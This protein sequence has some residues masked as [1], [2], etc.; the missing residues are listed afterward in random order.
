M[1]TVRRYKQAES[2][3]VL[4]QFKSGCVGSQRADTDSVF[5]SWELIAFKAC[6]CPDLRLVSGHLRLQANP[7][8]QNERKAAGMEHA[9]SR[10]MIVIVSWICFSCLFCLAVLRA[11][12]RPRPR[13]CPEGKGP[14]QADSSVIP[15]GEVPEREETASLAVTCS[16]R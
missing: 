6:F 1:E 5:G 16:S 8:L 14:G 12:V 3:S 2:C 4:K 15:K 9:F 13:H 11:A 10:I 7:V